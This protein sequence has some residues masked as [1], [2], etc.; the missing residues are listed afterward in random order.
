M[1]ATYEPI[2][3]TTLGTAA[4]SI[5]FSSISSAYTDF[6]VVLVGKCAGNASGNTFEFSINGDTGTNYSRTQL[7]GDGA[8][9]TSART[10][11]QTSISINT[12]KKLD[13]MYMVTVDA[14][15]YAGSTNKTFLMS[16]SGDFNTEGNVVRS[17][18]LYRSAS[19]V[20]SIAFATSGN[21]VSG[22]TATLYG[23]LK[24]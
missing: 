20:T 14:F 13:S 22:D 23:I 19:A 8:S 24:A 6:R 11:S 12:D 5:T 4:S 17:V 21:F 9:A 16:W 10:T 1:P 7:K 3:T 18:G 15:S 2:A